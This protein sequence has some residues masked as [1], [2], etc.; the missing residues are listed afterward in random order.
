MRNTQTVR[1][2]PTW[3]PLLLASHE[4]KLRAYSDPEI[5][6]K[7][8]DEAVEFKNNVNPPGFLGDGGTT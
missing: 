3:H 5:R 8:H 4:E 6:R 7:L 2:L 1:G